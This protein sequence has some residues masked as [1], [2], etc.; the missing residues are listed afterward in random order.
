VRWLI[1]PALAI[2]AGVGVVAAA[3]IDLEGGYGERVYFPSSASEVRPAYDL[4]AGRLEVD[5]RG[6]DFPPGERRLELEL[7]FGEAMLV[8]PEDLCVVVD[9]D[10]GAG[11]LRILQ[12]DDGGFNVGW[13]DGGA[14]PNAAVLVVD[15]HVGMGSLE[16]VHDPHDV[17]WQRERWEGRAP[18]DDFHEED[19]PALGRSA[20]C[21]ASA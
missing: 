4:G 12:W 5:L 14:A 2:A 6:V 15:A 21:E 7:G 18:W 19:D 16:V 13:D 1:V 3:D 10:V 8:V 11:Y 9:G 17:D 20:A